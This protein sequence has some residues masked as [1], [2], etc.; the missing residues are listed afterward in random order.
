VAE[1]LYNEI[2]FYIKNMRK[3]SH[4][5]QE[6]FN[7]DLHIYRIWATEA[8]C[9]RKHEWAKYH[10]REAKKLNYREPALLSI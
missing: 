5:M 1:S 9:R 6:A 10:A 2:F 3:A 8:S 7:I 4:A